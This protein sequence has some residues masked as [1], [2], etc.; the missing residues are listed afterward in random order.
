MFC[1]ITE[2]ECSAL[3]MGDPCPLSTSARMDVIDDEFCPF[4]AEE[5]GQHLSGLIVQ[6]EQQFLNAE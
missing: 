3:G 6:D 5:D 1:S 2:T 4:F